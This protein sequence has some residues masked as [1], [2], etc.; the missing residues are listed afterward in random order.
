MNLDHKLRFREAGFYNGVKPKHCVVDLVGSHRLR[1]VSA[2]FIQRFI[3]ITS[4]EE[5]TSPSKQCS[6]KSFLHELIPDPLNP[7]LKLRK[8]AKVS[9]LEILDKGLSDLGM[10]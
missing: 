5:I 2:A 7:T 9:R 10:L 4:L 3:I 8:S 1:I 6:K